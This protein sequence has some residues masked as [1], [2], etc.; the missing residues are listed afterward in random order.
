M[1]IQSG[2]EFMKCEYAARDMNGESVCK[3]EGNFCRYRGIEDDEIQAEIGRLK[4]DHLAAM[5]EKERE[6]ERARQAVPQDYLLSAAQ[7]IKTLREQIA[8]QGTVLNKQIAALQAESEGYKNGQAQL[9]SICNGLQDSISLYADGRRELLSDLQVARQT[10]ADYYAEF[11]RQNNDLQAEANR[12]MEELC[13]ARQRISELESEVE[14]M[15]A[16]T[17][18]KMEAEGK[19]AKA[20]QRIKELEAANYQMAMDRSAAER[21]VIILTEGHEWGFCEECEKIKT[22][23][24]ELD[25][26]IISPVTPLI[27]K[28]ADFIG[29]SDGLKSIACIDVA[30]DQANNL[31][32]QLSE[33]RERIEELTAELAAVKASKL[34]FV[35]ENSE[36]MQETY[37]DDNIRN[38]IEITHLEQEVVHAAATI[39]LRDERIKKLERALEKIR[40]HIAW[41]TN[42]EVPP[43]RV[44]PPSDVIKNLDDI[45]KTAL[46]KEGL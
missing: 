21:K 4:T 11:K 23:E 30:L 8:K 39:A 16:L 17:R 36:D 42:D 28:A 5:E 34:V 44:L 45:A 37:I 19:W 3:H 18:A 33:A 10:N 35:P 25:E 14:Y 1:T 13:K 24:T 41:R 12:N 27:D 43:Y 46:Q 15:D 29:C 6:I 7:T 9:Q 40:G 20:E 2:C 38:E 26:M 31:R 32:E 22:L